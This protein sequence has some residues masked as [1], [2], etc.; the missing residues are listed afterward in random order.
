VLKHAGQAEVKE[1]SR[2]EGEYTRVT[3]KRI[4][5]RITRQ[6]FS[7][8]VGRAGERAREKGRE[9]ARERE[10]DGDEEEVGNKQEKMRVPESSRF[11]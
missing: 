9:G 11:S 6:R 8:G 3:S 1:T 2:G 10:R 7:K 4:R 5:Q